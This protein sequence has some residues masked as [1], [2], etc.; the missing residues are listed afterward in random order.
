MSFLNNMSFIKKEEEI[1][2][3]LE[4]LKEEKEILQKQKEDIQHTI[5]EG[6]DTII[7]LTLL[8]NQLNSELENLKQ[9]NEKQRVNKRTLESTISSKNEEIEKLNENIK[10]LNI[11]IKNREEFYI[12]TEIKSID[13][14]SGINF[15][16]YC[17][18]LLEKTGYQN[19]EVTKASGD[20]GGDI[21]ATKGDIRYVFQCKRYQNIVGNKAIQEVHTAKSLYKCYKAIIITNSE[22]SHQAIY[23]AK[24][25]CIELWDYRKIKELLYIKYDFDVSHLDIIE[26]YDEEDDIDPFLIEAIE[27]VVERRSSIYIIITK[28]FENRI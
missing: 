3:E 18:E 6:K 19:V 5:N 28:R 12:R 23:E 8:K 20:E 21:I 22:F 2:Q 11:L 14:L 4:T 13:M 15:E 16:Y 26:E 24:E 27:L 9:E 25:L 10:K 7:E 17:G 1:K